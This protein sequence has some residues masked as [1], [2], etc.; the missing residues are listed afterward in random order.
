MPSPERGAGRGVAGP[1]PRPVLDAALG[2]D[3]GGGPAPGDAD[4]AEPPPRPFAESARTPPGRLRIAVST[5]SPIPL[6]KVYEPA[7]QAV[8][9]TAHALRP[10][11]HEGFER[12]PTYPAI[13]PSFLPAWP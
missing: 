10:P 11:G 9:P 2:L 5:K 3:A 7:K 12:A 6:V 4:R 13:R 8:R 1:V